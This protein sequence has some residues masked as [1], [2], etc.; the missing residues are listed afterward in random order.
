MRVKKQNSAIKL[1]SVSELIPV[2]ALRPGEVGRVSVEVH[3]PGKRKEGRH[4]CFFHLVNADGQ[5]FQGDFELFI[6]V[7]VQAALPDVT[8]QQFLRLA[9]Q[10]LVPEAKKVDSEVHEAL[11]SLLDQNPVPVVHSN[12]SCDGCQMFPL[13]GPRFKCTICE[14][15]DL[16]ESCEAEGNHPADHALI[17]FKQAVAPRGV[18][19]PHHHH[20]HRMGRH[21]FRRL[22]RSLVSEEQ[23]SPVRKI[24]PKA[25]FVKVELT[26]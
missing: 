6:D 17:K 11:R 15:F 20:H 24:E 12:V 4:T 16:C 21:L 7:I 5:K 8:K 26:I 23:P 19:R 22:G 2:P 10:F 3:L 9:S 1:T 18:N 14:D 13:V 25:D